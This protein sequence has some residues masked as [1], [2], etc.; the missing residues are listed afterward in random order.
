MDSI[1]WVLLGLALVLALY[2]WFKEHLRQKAEEAALE[3][4]IRMEEQKAQERKHL[5]RDMDCD[6]LR[7]YDGKKGKP[8][9]LAARDI[10]FDV[11]TNPESYG[12][13]SGYSI[14]AGRDASRGLGKM[15]LEEEDNEIR[16]I[17]DFT[18]YETE[19]LDQWIQMFLVKYEIVGKLT[20]S[21]NG[22]VPQAWI[23]KAMEDKK[24]GKDVSI[25]PGGLGDDEDDD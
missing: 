22:K 9:F 14:L 7:E 3:E 5:Y 23:D 16:H 4:E 12:P 20:D 10:I 15:S 25:L 6:A 13:D 21:I 17:K 2:S 18:R 1:T 24:A 19:T 11:T 8:I